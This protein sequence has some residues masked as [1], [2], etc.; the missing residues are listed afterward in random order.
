MCEGLLPSL[1][2]QAVAQFSLPAR[3]YSQ[4]I[5]IIIFFT[6]QHKFSALSTE[7]QSN[8]VFPRDSKRHCLFFLLL[9]RSQ[10][11]CLRIA[12]VLL[13]CSGRSPP[14]TRGVPGHSGCVLRVALLSRCL[15]AVR[16]TVLVPLP[17]SATSSQDS[18]CSPVRLLLLSSSARSPL[19]LGPC[20]CPPSVLPR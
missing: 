1:Y 7:A 4:G 14:P 18:F 15:A 3:K 5:I 2:N 19:A 9:K 6:K 16:V 10:A 17:I 12:T 13:A 20:R 11:F 8:T